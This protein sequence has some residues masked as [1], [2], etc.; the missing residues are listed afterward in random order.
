MTTQ[1]TFQPGRVPGLSRR[2]A[3]APPVRRPC[4]EAAPDA[5]PMTLRQRAALSALIHTPIRPATPRLTREDVGAGIAWVVV[6]ACALAWT[7]V[8]AIS[9]APDLSLAGVFEVPQVAAMALG[10]AV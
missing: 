5:P 1:L 4:P 3:G 7:L 10:G 8:I 9:L 6:T 2:N